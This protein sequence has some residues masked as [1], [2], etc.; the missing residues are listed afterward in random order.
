MNALGKIQIA[1]SLI[2]KSYFIG[3][4]MMF[5]NFSPGLFFS[6][7]AITIVICA[8][9]IMLFQPIFQSFFFVNPQDQDVFLLNPITSRLIIATC[10]ILS[11]MFGLLAYRRSKVIYAVSLLLLVLGG[12]TAY[13]STQSYLKINSEQIERNFLWMK[14][15][16]EWSELS[17]VYY[18]YV[19]GAYKGEMKLITKSG[20][21]FVIKEKELNSHAQSYIYRYSMEN[22]ISYIEREKQD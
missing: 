2:F 7:T 10:L 6:M 14:D 18:E 20:N 15:Q 13:F 9:Y 3:D 11:A 1:L 8:P 16:Y 19:V 5:K 17:E 21:S 22:G 12:S 4:G